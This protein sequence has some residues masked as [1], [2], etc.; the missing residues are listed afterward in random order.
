MVDESKFSGNTQYAP[1]IFDVTL[2]AAVAVVIA[3]VWLFA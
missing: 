2:I 3:I 1:N